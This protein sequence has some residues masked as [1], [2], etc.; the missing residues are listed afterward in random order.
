MIIS[1]ALR[2]NSGYFYCTATNLLGETESERHQIDVLCKY[3][4][5]WM[6]QLFHDGYQIEIL[7]S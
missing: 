3:L 6:R 4:K 1:S 2:S 5:I 7:N